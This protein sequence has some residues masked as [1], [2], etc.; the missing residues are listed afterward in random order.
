MAGLVPAIYAAP[1]SL[2]SKFIRNSAAWMAWTSPAMTS[3]DFKPE[4]RGA[5]RS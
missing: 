4:S 3:F 5:G 2:T 1:L